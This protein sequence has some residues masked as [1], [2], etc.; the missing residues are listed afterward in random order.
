MDA[1][2][3]SAPSTHEI[4]LDPSLFAMNIGWRLAFGLAAIM[5]FGILLVR[6]NVPQSPR[7]LFHRHPVRPRHAERDAADGR[8][9]RDLLLRVCRRERGLSDGQRDLPHGNPRDGDR[10]LLRDRDHRRRVRRAAP[11]RA[12]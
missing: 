10:V 3:V 12:R 1:R 11:V 9:V 2:T 7:W 6:R 5:G 4:L 8:L